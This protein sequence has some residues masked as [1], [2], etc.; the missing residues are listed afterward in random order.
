VILTCRQRIEI[1]LS[2]D[3]HMA[4]HKS[5]IVVL[6]LSEWEDI[7]RFDCDHPSAVRRSA[8]GRR[9]GH[10]VNSVNHSLAPG[11]KPSP[12]SK[13]RRTARNGSLGGHH[14]PNWLP[15]FDSETITPLQ[16]FVSDADDGSFPLTDGATI[17]SI[18]KSSFVLVLAFPLFRPDSYQ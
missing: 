1:E 12:L 18:R 4:A 6:R 8:G 17:H 7:V 14:S 10:P 11:K 13:S 3:G 16:L 15:G 2:P 9:N 5:V